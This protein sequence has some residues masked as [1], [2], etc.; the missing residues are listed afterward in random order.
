MSRGQLWADLPTGEDLSVADYLARW[1]AHARGR[2]RA[3]TYEG[4]GALIRLHAIPQLEQV[5]LRAL[6]PLRIQHLYD[7]LLGGPGARG[8][9]G[10]GTVL[11]LHLVLTQALGQAV[12]W[13]LLAS[14]PAA[15]AQPPRPRRP[16]LQVVTAELARRMLEAA[17]G[18]RLELPL[19]IAIATGMRRGEILGL[20]WEDLDD[21]LTLAQVRR[22]LQAT[23]GGL[24][25]EQPKTPRSRRAVQ[26]RPS[27]PASSLNRSPYSSE[28][29]C[30]WSCPRAATAGRKPFGNRRPAVDA[31][32]FGG[33]SRRARSDEPTAITRA[34]GSVRE[35]AGE[36]GLQAG[37]RTR[38][39]V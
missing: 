25:F 12:R 15:G 6:S 38:T 1:L 26:S 9:L 11:N 3:K 23:G 8:P 13:G 19:A 29:A 34:K 5:R 33:I 10:A 37:A 21:G 24:V 28:A 14:N 4:Y 16:E 32:R 18:T 2:V 17:A 7:E 27:V 31:T 39:P 22:S 20:R 30:I 36:H 35:R